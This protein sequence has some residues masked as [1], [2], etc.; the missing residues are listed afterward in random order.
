MHGGWNSWNPWK[1]QQQKIEEGGNSEN[2]GI[3]G[4]L[5]QTSL[6]NAACDFRMFR[7]SW[8]QEFPR[9]P[10]IRGIPGMSE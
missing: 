4:D 2:H 6:K 5:L 7:D 8:F 1:S 3:L 10:G 9:V